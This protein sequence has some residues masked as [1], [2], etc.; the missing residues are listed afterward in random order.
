MTRL[1]LAK[2]LNLTKAQVYYREKVLGIIGQ[3]YTEKNIELIRNKR[4][5]KSKALFQIL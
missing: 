3:D 1:E 4:N 5:F 2:Q